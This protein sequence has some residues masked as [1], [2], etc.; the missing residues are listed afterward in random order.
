MVTIRYFGFASVTFPGEAEVTPG[1]NLK[2]FII[3]LLQGQ[4][5]DADFFMDCHLIV[6][7]GLRMEP[8]TTIADEDK[9]YIF[10]HATIG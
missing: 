7:N 3:S 4:E 2:E 1:K 10:P 9:I 5:V 8:D 6:K